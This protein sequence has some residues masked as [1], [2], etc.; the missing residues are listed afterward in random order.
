MHCHEG[1]DRCVRYKTMKKI[2]FFVTL[3]S[4][5]FSYAQFNHEAS[6]EAFVALLKKLSEQVP[7]ALKGYQS[8]TLIDDAKLAAGNFSRNSTL[9]VDLAKKTATVR[10]VEPPK[11]EGLKK[12][13]TFTV[14]VYLEN[15]KVFI[16]QKFD[17]DAASN[18]TLPVNVVGDTLQAP[19]ETVA[20]VEKRKG[21]L[22][23][24][25]RERAE[26]AGFSETPST[27]FTLVFGLD[28]EN[29]GVYMDRIVSGISSGE[30]DED[31]KDDLKTVKLRISL[32][33]NAI[34]A[35]EE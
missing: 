19:S 24:Q 22:V 20:E 29:K 32:T 5:L 12:G 31:G 34:P 26:A 4:P 30:K 7:V 35:T 14:E 23:S 8:S 9:T 33:E 18:W 2:L 15:S 21:D 6:E 28:S 27:R 1:L 25:L 10:V 3:L 17:R 11:K 16:S 13:G